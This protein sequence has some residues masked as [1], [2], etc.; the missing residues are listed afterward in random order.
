M[1]NLQVLFQVRE[2]LGRDHVQNGSQEP[3]LRDRER[4][5]PPSPHVP[6]GL[7]FSVFFSRCTRNF[8]PW[9][10]APEGAAPTSEMG[11]RSVAFDLL[12]RF[13]HSTICVAFLID[14]SRVAGGLM[15]AAVHN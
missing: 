14:L 10:I 7:M 6:F 15:P 2:L 8:E 3:R 12:I 11:N 5:P 4:V 9:R 1:P 13:K